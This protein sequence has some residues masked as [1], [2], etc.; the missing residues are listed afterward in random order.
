MEELLKQILEELKYQT[1]LLESV[2]ERG[3]ADGVS[4]NMER[5]MQMVMNM[6]LMQQIGLRP[7]TMRSMMGMKKPCSGGVSTNT[8]MGSKKR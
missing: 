2:V 8:P 3:R 6:P 1:K 4:E 7:D 5:A